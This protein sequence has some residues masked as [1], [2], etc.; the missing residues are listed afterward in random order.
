MSLVRTTDL[1]T[2]FRNWIIL[3]CIGLFTNFIAF[4][5]TPLCPKDENK[6]TH[7]IVSSNI[8]QS[9]QTYRTAKDYLGKEIRLQA[10]I[11]Q[12]LDLK[13]QAYKNERPLIILYHGGGLKSGSRNTAIMQSI[14]RYFAQRGYV[15]VSPDYR[16]GWKDSDK[17]PLCGGGEQ[18]D[19]LDA[20]YRAMQDERALV[21]YFK[22]QAKNIGFDTN[23]IFML[24][25]S[26]GATLVVSRL[27]DEWISKDD[28][29]A[30]RLGSLEEKSNYSTKV[31]GL[32]SFEGANLSPYVKNNFDTPVCFFHG[33][34]DNAVP[35]EQQYLAG[36]SSLGYY[37]GPKVL[38]TALDKQKVCYHSYIYCGFGHDL[39]AEGDAL[40]EIPW[41]LNDV[42]TRSIDFIQDILCNQC[43]TIKKVVNSEQNILPV[44]QCN[45]IATYDECSNVVL[46]QNNKIE[47]TP[48]LF[49]DDFSIYIYTSFDTD[50]E[51]TLHIYNMS[52][53]L[54]QTQKLNISKGISTYST[55]IKPLLNGVYLYQFL[56]N[57]KVIY[58]GK[59]WKL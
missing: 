9:T 52:G 31:A 30:E 54:I 56:D 44:A 46:I 51:L 12:S 33:T 13:I 50:K 11:Y 55:T 22:S 34:C 3:V 26:S 49:H 6:F 24:G 42:L 41:G 15:A 48:T 4:S 45:P 20:Q 32:L 57:K 59:L 27:E 58:S 39:A 47:L 2:K 36:C 10:D 18:S 25:I 8:V 14:A 53:G 19:Y 38:T 5:Q 17:T 37:Y 35:Y 7:Q 29:R 16:K 28:N 21:Q 1:A 43:Q 40:R 23:R